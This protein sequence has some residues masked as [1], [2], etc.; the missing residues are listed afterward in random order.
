MRARGYVRVPCP[1]EAQQAACHQETN[2]QYKDLTCERETM[3]CIEKTDDDDDVEYCKLGLKGAFR[4]LG[5]GG[6]HSVPGTNQFVPEP[7][8]SGH[9]DGRWHLACTGGPL[10]GTI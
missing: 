3:V 6:F 8:P 9:S 4:G 2:T 7:N 10:L 1:D 5:L